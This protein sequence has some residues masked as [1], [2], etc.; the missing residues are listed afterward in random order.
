M[1]VL[2]R[3]YVIT[4]DG[5]AGSGKSTVSMMLAERLSYSYL[6]TGALYRAVAYRA[7]KSA[8]QPDDEEGLRNLCNRIRVDVRNQKGNL[9]VFVDDEDVSS[10]IRSPKVSMMA[11]RV[12]AVPA[13]RQALLL[14]QRKTGEK[15]GI[16]AEGRDMGTVVFP[17]ADFKFY[18][19]ASV[20]ARSRRR[21]LEL[22]EKGETVSL[23]DVQKDVIRRDRQDTD[24]EMAPL[25]PSEGAIFIDSTNLGV[26][27]V[28]EKMVEM[29]EKRV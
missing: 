25:R 17:G 9:K 1:D 21:Y 20:E 11:S 13:V 18:L 26:S 29:I 2:K 14:L 8:I 7:S 16:V 15:G 24:R 10:V 12:S 6:D 23:E 4:I 28:I 22:V 19:T 3:P 5:P 27:E